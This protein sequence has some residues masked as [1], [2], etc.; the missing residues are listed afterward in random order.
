MP[1]YIAMQN[2]PPVMCNDEEAMEHTKRQGR[3]GEEVHRR[4]RLSVVVQECRPALRRLRGSRCFPH[5]TKHCPLRDIE[6]EH[7]QLAMN[8]RRTPSLVFAYH[9]K[10]KLAHFLA[11]TSSAHSAATPREPCPVQCEAGS[12]P[13]NDR[14]R[15]HENQR[16][17]PPRPESS[18]HHPKQFVRSGKPD[19]RA[20]SF[21]R[22]EL[23]PKSEIFQE[24]IAARTKRPCSHNEQKP[25]QVQHKACASPKCRRPLVS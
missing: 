23:L 24:Q 3:D 21:Q 19:L 4:N 16:L 14:L 22:P 25:Q 5:P 6:A 1:G 8:A 9:A 20:P 12:V 13:T 18:Q 15:P 7:R 10:D 17:L 2:P 11:H